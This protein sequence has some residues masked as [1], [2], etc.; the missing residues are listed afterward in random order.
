ML[1]RY[2]ILASIPLPLSWRYSGSTLSAF[3]D[4]GGFW[5]KVIG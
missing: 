5:T 2:F 4:G 1:L 3:T